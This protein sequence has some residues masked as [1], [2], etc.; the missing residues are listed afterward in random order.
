MN[1]LQ[2][3]TSGGIDVLDD[4]VASGL[5]NVISETVQTVSAEVATLI[6]SEFGKGKWSFSNF[7]ET[8]RAK[9][10]LLIAKF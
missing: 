9:S 6:N 3:I 2:S 1:L 7:L 10:L 8:Q 4:V 5:P